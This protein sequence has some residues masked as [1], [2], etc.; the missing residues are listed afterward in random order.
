MIKTPNHEATCLGFIFSNPVSME[1]ASLI[2]AD[3]HEIFSD[4]VPADVQHGSKMTATRNF[5]F[6]RVLT[7]RAE[8]MHDDQ[9]VL[10]K[11]PGNADF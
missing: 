3:R 5:R 1:T 6:P 4:V 9:E 11:C 10:N 8:H 2:G 7:N